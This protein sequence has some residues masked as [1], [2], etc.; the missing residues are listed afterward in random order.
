M[1]SY[2]FRF[3]DKNESNRQNQKKVNYQRK[4]PKNNQRNPEI[5]T[6][7]IIFYM[8]VA[9]KLS[10]QCLNCFQISS[11]F[12]MKQGSYNTIERQV[13]LIPKDS[14]NLNYIHYIT[15]KKINQGT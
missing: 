5:F 11:L 2:T 15:G 1:K 13:L 8:V 3:F 14:N 10:F 4:N 12:Y 9:E 6:S 7:V